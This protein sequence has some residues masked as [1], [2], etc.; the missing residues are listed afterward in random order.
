[1][2]KSKLLSLRQLDRKIKPLLKAGSVEIPSTGWIKNI[3]N[4][5]NMT[6]SQLG[7]KLNISRQSVFEI[8]WR[9]AEGSISLKSLQEVGQAMDLKL[10]YGFIPEQDSFE[11]MVEKKAEHLAK[12]IVL[13]THQ[14]M[15]L[16]DQAV[17]QKR[18]DESVKELTQEIKA[19]MRKTLWD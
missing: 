8:E 7:E 10:V 5:L 14:N 1:M 13:R 11:G 4:T 2:R 19:E 3:R 16:E 18:I 9:E 17:N 12:K 15:K 6:Q